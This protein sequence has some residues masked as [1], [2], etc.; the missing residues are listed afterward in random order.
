MFVG[1]RRQNRLALISEVQELQERYDSIDKIEELPLTF[2]GTDLYES[3][4][5]EPTKSADITLFAPIVFD[6]EG[7]FRHLCSHPQMDEYHKLASDK[8]TQK[9]F[10]ATD[11][12]KPPIPLKKD[13]LY[14]MATSGAGQ[15]IAG[16]RGK[17]LHLQRGVAEV[18]EHTEYVDDPANP[19]G[20]G[21]MKVTTHTSITMTI[22]E[23]SG[24]ITRLE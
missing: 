23:T 11:I 2:E 6:V 18:V 24:K 14:L 16:E 7:A 8:A 9:K 4:D 20:N 3:I 12:G 1:R 10:K 21:I 13:S 5:V 17:D 19:D 15:G 22:I